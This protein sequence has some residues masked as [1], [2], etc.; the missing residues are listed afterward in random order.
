MESHLAEMS[1]GVANQFHHA[2]RASSRV[3]AYISLR[4]HGRFIQP[5]GG[6]CKD[7]CVNGFFVLV[8]CFV[9]PCIGHEIK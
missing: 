6:F 3:A 7:N 2:V 9:F 4:P 5:S 8:F 1:F